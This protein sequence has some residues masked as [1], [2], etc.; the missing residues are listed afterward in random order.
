VADRTALYYYAYV[1]F[2]LGVAVYFLYMTLGQYVAPSFTIAGQSINEAEL[3]AAVYAAATIVVVYLRY[4]EEQRR[5]AEEAARA[6]PKKAAG[7]R[8]RR[9]K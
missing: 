1:G 9:G 2:A 5:A 6:Q 4:V 3:V 8:K 7:G